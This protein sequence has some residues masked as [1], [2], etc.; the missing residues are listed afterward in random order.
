M[1][2][3][4]TYAIAT[5]LIGAAAFGAVTWLALESQEV[6]VLSTRQAGGTTRATRVWVARE[7]QSLWLESA[8]PERP[9]YHDV[10]ADPRVEMQLGGELLQ[11][12]AHPV[13]GERGHRKIRDLLSRKYGWA[14]AWVGLVQDTSRSIAVRLDPV[15]AREPGDSR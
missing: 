2:K 12:R 15:V 13:Q 4:A 8:T 14:D 9:W 7:R 1:P 11:L 3:R 5:A 6:A 10:L